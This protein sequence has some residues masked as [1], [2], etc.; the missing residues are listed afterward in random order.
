MVRFTDLLHWSVNILMSIVPGFGNM[1]FLPI[2]VPCG[3]IPSNLQR[4]QFRKCLFAF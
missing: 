2:A 4:F 3:A 1:W